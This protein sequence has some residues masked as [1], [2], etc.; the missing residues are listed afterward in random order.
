MNTKTV[1]C[2][3]N[4]CHSSVLFNNLTVGNYKLSFL[5]FPSSIFTRDSYSVLVDL[6]HYLLVVQFPQPIEVHETYGSNPLADVW[7]LGVATYIRD[8]TASGMSNH[9][10]DHWSNWPLEYPSLFFNGMLKMSQFTY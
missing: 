7:T 10:A 4:N 3:S 8:F 5:N 2:D 6:T 1:I 9:I